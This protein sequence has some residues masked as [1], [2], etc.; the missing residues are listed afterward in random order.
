MFWPGR[1]PPTPRLRRRRRAN[2]VCV[3]AMTMAGMLYL[4]SPY[5]T[6]WSMGAALQS[7]DKTALCASLD[8]EQVRS[9]MKD[10]LGLRRPVQQVSQ[11]DEL[12]GFGESFVTGIASG[13]IDDD[14]TP[15]RL[16]TMLKGAKARQHGAT[17]LPRGYFVGPARFEARIQVAGDTPIE[18][19]MRIEKWHWKVTRV[20][21]PEDLMNPPAATHM[22][23]AK[24]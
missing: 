15:E 22:A 13:M 11:Q 2:R 18:I 4:A 14:I 5:M 6:L 16:G 3:G 17:A 23:S 8:W 7:H 1:T 20:T 19:T 10:E 12:P 9:G 21:L 24:S